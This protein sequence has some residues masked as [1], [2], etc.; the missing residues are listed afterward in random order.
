VV[1]E[2]SDRPTDGRSTI[3]VYGVI[4]S[5]VVLQLFAVPGLPALSVG[6]AAGL[7]L[8]AWAFVVG[9]LRLDAPRLCAYLLALAA[10]VVTLA[11]TSSGFSAM[12]FLM[13]ATIY[14]P[15][16]L[17]A[18]TNRIGYLLILDAYQRVAIFV[19]CCGI[20]QFAIQFVAGSAWMFPFHVGLPESL[21]IPLYNL[22]IP[23]T[24]GV[25][26]LKSTG[27]WFLEPSL[28]A[29]ALAFAILIEV[30][31]FRRLAV[32]L[33]YGLAYVTSFSGTG[34]VL[35]AVV[36]IP[37]LVRLRQFW[38]LLAIAMFIFATPLLGNVPPFSFFMERL[39]E[40]AN[41]L[42]SG[43]MRFFAPYWLTYDL[44]LAD[45][46][47]FWF[48]LGPGSTAGIYERPDYAVL[49]TFWLKLLLEYGVL[50]GVPFMFFYLL[51]LFY[52]TPDK[53]LSF[54]FLVQSMFLGGYLNS[55]FIQFLMLMLVG[56]PRV[57]ECGRV[58]WEDNGK[59]RG[60]AS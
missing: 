5:T 8:I 25:G 19:A 46:S 39:D 30:L 35:L 2:F 12:S 44:I 54:A 4:L 33:L 34:A 9:L 28:F 38:P 59:G 6:L 37:V 7:M 29:Q 17:V 23:I 11:V 58:P 36:A 40:F 20:G 52:R 21:F 50:G 47:V 10:L 14:L 32:L 26:Y 55:Y 53:T 15:F 16:T 18:A 31:Y 24:D 1:R 49:D 57:T 45:P 43:S 13:L 27:L 22:R 48:G 51:I 60:Q 42:S 56:W 41:P 3:L